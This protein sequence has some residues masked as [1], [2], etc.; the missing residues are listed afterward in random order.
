MLPLV[1][2]GKNAEEA[3]AGGTLGWGGQSFSLTLPCEMKGTQ[4]EGVSVPATEVQL[5]Q[6]WESLDQKPMHQKPTLGFLRF[7]R[8]RHSP[9]DCCHG[10]SWSG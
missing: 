2:L 3:A 6:E 1:P 7:P 4:R 9:G 5:H 8:E 10:S